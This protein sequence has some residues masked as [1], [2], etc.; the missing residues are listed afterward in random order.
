MSFQQPKLAKKATEKRFSQKNLV[1]AL[2]EVHV[3]VMILT[4]PELQIYQ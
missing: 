2:K 4:F 3:K 1:R